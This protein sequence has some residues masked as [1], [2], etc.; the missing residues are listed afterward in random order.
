VRP[1]LEHSSPV[2]LLA[3]HALSRFLR[4]IEP[5]SPPLVSGCPYALLVPSL[6]YPPPSYLVSPTPFLPECP[7]PTSQSVSSQTLRSTNT[8]MYS[9][10]LCG[11]PTVLLAEHSP[12]PLFPLLF[13]SVLDSITTLPHRIGCSLCLQFRRSRQLRNEHERTRKV[14]LD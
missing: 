5:V 7:L 9:P 3:S 10:Y 8:F 2:L 11:L 4:S 6:Q 12:H 1:G 13:P 14:H